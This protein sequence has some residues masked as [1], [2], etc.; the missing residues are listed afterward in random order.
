M[1]PKARLPTLDEI[2]AKPE[3][4]NHLTL[5]EVAELRRKLSRVT[6]VLFEAWPE[7]DDLALKEILAEASIEARDREVIGRRARGES[8]DQI[9]AAVRLTPDEV[10]AIIDAHPHF[11][12]H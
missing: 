3:L 1:K 7:G 6:A 5:D 8:A 9:A 10:S 12:K 11:R 2:V 4:V